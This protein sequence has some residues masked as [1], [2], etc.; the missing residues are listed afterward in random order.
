MKILYFCFF[1]IA[2][3]VGC[4]SAKNNKIPEYQTVDYVTVGKLFSTVKTPYV[5]DLSKGSKR[6]VFIGCS[7]T[8]D[9]TSNEFTIIEKYFGELQPQLAIHEGGPLADFKRYTTRSEAITRHGETG[10]LKYLCDRANVKMLS[11]DL[12]D[13]LEFAMTLKKYPKQELFL[14]YVMERLV[15]P[16]L[17]NAYGNKPFEAFYNEVVEDWFVKPG[18]PLTEEEKSFAY[19]KQLYQQEIGRPFVLEPN[20]DNFEKFD[21]INGGDCKYCAIGRA[22][23]EARDKVLLDKIDRAFNQYNKV[24]VTFGHGHALAIEPALKQII[25]KNRE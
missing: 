22:S 15:N 14:Y 21:Y 13:S 7:H 25:A 20:E 11:G 3:L 10:L 12:S 2:L 1:S 19:F 4:Q 17:N 5:I 8:R 9:T 23:K 24:I 16:Y 18:I 6:L